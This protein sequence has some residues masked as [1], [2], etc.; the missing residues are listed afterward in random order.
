MENGTD[1]EKISHTAVMCAKNL[2]LQT[3][4]PYA[5]EIWEHLKEDNAEVVRQGNGLVGN[6][7]REVIMHLPK[8]SGVRAMLEGRYIAVNKV[9]ENEGHPHVMELASGLS[10]RG[11]DFTRQDQTRV[12][13]ET[14]LPGIQ[15]VKRKIVDTIRARESAEGMPSTPNYRLIPLNVTDGR[16]FREIVGRYADKFAERPLAVVNAGLLM[17]LN[18]DEQ[19]KTR[20]NI[21]SALR[22]Y[23]PNG[24]WITPD[25]VVDM[26]QFRK[27][28][29]MKFMIK[30]VEKKTGRK[31]TSFDSREEAESFLREGGFEK[32]SLIGSAYLADNLSSVRKLRLDPDK[33]REK[34]SMYDVYK[35]KLS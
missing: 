16:K 22:E 18:R 7:L 11:L 6:I 28:P 21:A 13:L 4:V 15:A 26:N 23:S 1:H 30:G 32:I 12:Y 34:A 19:R 31:L 20:D 27:N 10:P 24:M 2:G 33:V 9:L 25:L 17:Y 5:R 35:A 8:M 14:D 29:V 3:D